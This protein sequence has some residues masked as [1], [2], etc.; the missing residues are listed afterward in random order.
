G[1]TAGTRCGTF[2]R[3]AT[4]PSGPNDGPSGDPGGGPGG[5][6]RGCPWRGAAP[7]FCPRPWL[8]LADLLGPPAIA[9]SAIVS[10][11]SIHPATQGSSEPPCAGAKEGPCLVLRATLKL[12]NASA[13]TS[14]CCMSTSRVQETGWT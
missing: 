5:A 3:P 13:S 4:G 8:P 10:S 7:G 12:A 14:S 6:R 2:F 9:R 11:F 1:C